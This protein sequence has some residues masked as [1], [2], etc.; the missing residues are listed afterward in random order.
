LFSEILPTLYESQEKLSV[1][2]RRFFQPSVPSSAIAS[3]S[4]QQSRNTRCLHFPDLVTPFR[5]KYKVK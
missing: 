3:I 1:G 2:F 5:L 4:E